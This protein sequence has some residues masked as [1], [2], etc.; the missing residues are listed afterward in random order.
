[1]KIKFI[2]EYVAVDPATNS[3]IIHRFGETEEI[4]DYTA[5]WLIDNGFAEEVR[6][7]GWWKPKLGDVYYV[8]Y[9]DGLIASCTWDGCT[10]DENR[11]FNGASFKTEEAAE[12]WRDYLKAIATVRQDEGVIDLQGICEEYETEDNKYNDFSVYTV[13][14]DLYLRRLVVTDADEYISANAIWFEDEEHAQS[15]LDNHP[16]EWKTIVNYDW[17]RET[18]YVYKERYAELSNNGKEDK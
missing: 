11:F 12:H 16:D 10:V 1:M 8:V 3:G 2:K 15:S 14:F 9:P 7:S 6:E 5:Q 13:A 17:G 18:E 4:K